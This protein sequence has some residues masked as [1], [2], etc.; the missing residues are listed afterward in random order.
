M[1]NQRIGLHKCLFE[2][3]IMY[4]EKFVPFAEMIFHPTLLPLGMI[5]FLLSYH[6]G[7]EQILIVP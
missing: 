3:I 5:F 2:S 7:S 4:N 1:L 6:K